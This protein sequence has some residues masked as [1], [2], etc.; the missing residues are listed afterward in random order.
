MRIRGGLILIGGLSLSA[1]EDSI[2]P[3]RAGT[4][5]VSTST[6]GEDPDQD[7]YLLALDDTD[8]LGLG[9]TQTAEVELGPGRHTL[10]L[11]G[12]AGHCSVSPG[13]TL[14]A[15]VGPGG[16]TFVA[17]TVS[18]PATGARVTVTTSGLDVDPD[19][20]RVAADESDRA[21]IAR[22][23][24][25]LILLES[26]NRTIALTGLASNCAVDGLSSRTVTIADKV[27]T[28]IE[29][30]VV[31]TAT[32]GVIKVVVSGDV[33][34]IPF[35]VTLDGAS[36][37]PLLSGDPE[38]LTRVPVGDHMVSLS[39]PGCTVATNPQPVTI[40]SGVL[41][42][43]TATVS[44]LATC[45][46]TGNLRITAPTTG[47]LPDTRYEV[48]TCSGNNCFY[49]YNIHFVGRVKPNGVLFA[50]HEP[51]TYHIWMNLPG[52]CLPQFNSFDK[53][54]T[55]VRGD[56]LNLDLPVACS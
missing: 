42:R 31:C 41:T 19:G 47:P 32:S 2:D 22:Q 56:T 20:Y 1:C 5:V 30:A 34:G 27:V 52:N 40:A 43:D 15:D 16:T 6:T 53:Q 8:S 37:P 39:A 13:A 24:T 26:G 25:V 7:G 3:E 46:R 11:L 33:E 50:E 55:L 36:R 21:A 29:F 45:V 12:V 44:F 48:L 54:F 18:C 49:N 9:P 4:L 51:G 17:F 23:G 38:Y 10:R 14:E 35:E 28:P